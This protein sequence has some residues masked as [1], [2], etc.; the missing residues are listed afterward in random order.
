MDWTPPHKLH[1]CPINLKL[2][3]RSQQTHRFSACLRS[4]QL[5][6]RIDVMPRRR[7]QNARWRRAN[8]QPRKPGPLAI[9]FNRRKIKLA[10]LRAHA[11]FDPRIKERQREVSDLVL[12]NF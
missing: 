4:Q 7:R 10:N 2:L 6:K 3:I 11:L 8:I 9:G 5:G 12:L 1:R